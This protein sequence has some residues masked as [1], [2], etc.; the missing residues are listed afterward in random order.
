VVHH[1]DKGAKHDRDS[2]EYYV[3]KN[4]GGGFDVEAA[5][6]DAAAGVLAFTHESAAAEKEKKKSGMGALQGLSGQQL[7]QA[8]RIGGVASV[9]DMDSSE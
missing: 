1:Y 7:P 5:L 8:L 2:K 4:K 6:C 9:T 3:L